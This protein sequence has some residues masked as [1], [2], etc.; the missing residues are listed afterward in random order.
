MRLQ[1]NQFHGA[2]PRRDARLLGEYEAQIAEN[3]RLYSGALGS[4]RK[5]LLVKA[6]GTNS[7]TYSNTF[8]NAAWTKIGGSVNENVQT[9]PD[10]SSTMDTIVEDSSTGVHGVS[11][12]VLKSGSAETWTAACSFKASGR[13]YAFVEIKDAS[14]GLAYAVVNL[15]TGAIVSQGASGGFT[16][17]TVE[18]TLEDNSCVRLHVTALVSALS[19]VTMRAGGALGTPAVE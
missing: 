1:I 9:A 19:A 4:W 13:Q 10:G 3:C 11:Q 15:T 2:R 7:L 16:L 18:A 8:S 17:S 5:P 6:V 14:S 12:A